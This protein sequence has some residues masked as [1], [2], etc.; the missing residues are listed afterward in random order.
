MREVLV[1]DAGKGLESDASEGREGR[2]GGHPARVSDYGAAGRWF[3]W[4]FR[5]LEEP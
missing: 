1:K 2:A 4:A 3:S 5:P